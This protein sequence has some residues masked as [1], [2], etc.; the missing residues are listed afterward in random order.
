M[1][2]FKEAVFYQVWPR[3]FYDTN[4]DGIGDLKGIIAKL[5]H[6]KSCHV[7]YIWISPFYNSPQDDYG[8]DVSD[9]MSVASEYGT[10]D[11]FKELVAKAKALDI[12]IICD[13]VANHTSTSHAWFQEAL[14]NPSSDK[15]DYYF[16]RPVSE[17]LPNNWI[18]IFGGSA[19]TQVS[20][21][22]Y[23]LTLFTPTQAD[24]NWDNPKVRDEI[25][26]IM[27]TWL[28]LGI[29]GFRLDVFN[30]ISKIEGLISKD[31]HK[32]GY[33]FADDYI[34][35]RPLGQ[36]Y[37]KDLL[38][39]LKQDYDFITIGEGMLI[40]QDAA[41]IMCG[42]EDDQLDLII[43][44]DLHMLGC[45]PL[46]KFDFR[47]FY[48]YTN[49]DFKRVLRSW[50]QAAQDHKFHIASTMSNHDQPRAVSRFGDDKTFRFESAKALFAINFF[51]VGSPFIYQGE[52]IAMKNM[53]LPMEEW[54]DF[55][56]I[57]TYKALQSMMKVPAFLAKKIIQKM[58]RDHARGVMQWDDSSYGGFSQVKPWFKINDDF[59]S[60]NVMNQE[61]DPNSVLNYV[62]ALS[63]LY[64][65][66][67]TLSLGGWSE[68]E[69]DHPHLI[70]MHRQ[71]D[72]ALFTLVCN[73]SKK[74]IQ[75]LKND[76]G[77]LV[78]SNIYDSKESST[79]LHPYETH[80]YYKNL[81]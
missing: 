21:H 15:R 54:K 45:G 23:A 81:K 16:F 66:I 64:H 9:Y 24:L 30:T 57:N 35:D 39:E 65:E 33:Q 41:A 51:N 38:R 19:W 46:G 40:S 68:S 60:I 75:L 29:A 67:P 70:V 74:K 69:I 56:A 27:K 22:D 80:I 49:K 5:D 12:G 63:S 13:L 62:R 20:E 50:N 28:D 55:E 26:Q 32:K 25:K 61:H 71:D 37:L 76:Y 59:E 53:N 11:D 14:Q 72:S 7:D 10:M 3:S 34:R 31:S 4:Q 36:K 58:S 79:I 6:I 8:Y 43:H 73:F 2:P 17:G 48:H 1:K 44:F 78:L 52:E 47:K 18:S 77:R 42:P